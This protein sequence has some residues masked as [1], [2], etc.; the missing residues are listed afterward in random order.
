M[1]DCFVTQRAVLA[2]FPVG[3]ERLRP[4]PDYDFIQPPHAGRLFYETF[5]WGM[6]GMRFRRLAAEALDALGLGQAR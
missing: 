2:A 3:T 1:L 6:T 5:P 4:A